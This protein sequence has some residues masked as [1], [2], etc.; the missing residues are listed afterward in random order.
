[1]SH[2]TKKFLV[3]IFVAAGAVSLA[4]QAAPKKLTTLACGGGVTITDSLARLAP[5]DTLTVSGTC[6]E[7]LF[8][9]PE[10]SNITNNGQGTATIQAASPRRLLSIDD[11]NCRGRLSRAVR[12][13]RHQD[14]C[15][16]AH[17]LS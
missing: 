6:I 8:V 3:A 1:M 4:V 13:R 5:G 11:E 14:A 16:A 17:P 15:R 7:N 12:L 10:I 2:S 9:A